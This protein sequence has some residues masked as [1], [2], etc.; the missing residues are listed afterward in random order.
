MSEVTG[1][2]WDDL[3]YPYGFLNIKG[4]GMP[5]YPNFVRGNTKVTKSSN[6]SKKYVSS[7]N[8]T[9][10]ITPFFNSRLEIIDVKKFIE[11]GG[12]TVLSP[13]KTYVI[14][15]PKV[16]IT[17]KD[18]QIDYEYGKR[19]IVG[20]TDRCGG[21]YYLVDKIEYMYFFYIRPLKSVRMTLNLEE[22]TRNE[23]TEM[24]NAFLDMPTNLFHS[25]SSGNDANT[26]GLMCFQHNCNRNSMKNIVDNS[27][28]QD[29]LTYENYEIYGSTHIESIRGTFVRSYSSYSNYGGTFEYEF[30]NTPLSIFTEEQKLDLEMKANGALIVMEDSKVYV[31]N[32]CPFGG[33]GNYIPAISKNKKDKTK[34][35]H[36]LTYKCVFST[37]GLVNNPVK[38]TI[39]SLLFNSMFKFENVATSPVGTP[40]LVIIPLLNITY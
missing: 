38:Q 29:V 16:T 9:S 4:T 3:R 22:Y 15:I 36:T 25:F 5:S 10:E 18:N 12:I 32:N 19:I 37:P 26:I 1:S 21:Q 14:K 40:G 6:S 2:G 7:L 24:S 35:P 8:M 34:L 11:D 30:I 33:P 17:T 27:E 31:G 13:E 20:F 23:R 28:M 39:I